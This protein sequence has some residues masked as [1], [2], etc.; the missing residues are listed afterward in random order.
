MEGPERSVSRTACS[1]CGIVE[2]N[3]SCSGQSPYCD[4]LKMKR[5]RTGGF[6]FD[7]FVLC[8]PETGGKSGRPPSCCELVTC[9]LD[10]GD[11]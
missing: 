10:P 3:G 1:A 9:H 11:V 5:R 2:G 6:T 8:V 7:F 4:E